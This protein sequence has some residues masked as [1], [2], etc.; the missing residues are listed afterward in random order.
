MP[1]SSFLHQNTLEINRNSISILNSSL[2]STKENNLV[3]A[4]NTYRASMGNQTLT[5]SPILTNIAHWMANDLADN[6]YFSHTDSLNRSGYQRSLDFGYPQG[7]GEN[8]AASIIWDTPESAMTAWKNSPG[9]NQNMLLP[10]YTKIGVAYKYKPDSLYGHYW[11]AEFGVVED[12]IMTTDASFTTF[13][14][15]T[16]HIWEGK[17][18]DLTQA[19]DLDTILPNISAIFWWNNSD[20]KFDFWF[21]GFPDS[22]SVLKTLEK[23]NYYFFQGPSGSKVIMK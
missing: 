23:G 7:A 9:H 17:N 6:N 22:F 12:P 4:I 20:Q 5:E 15:A 21:K 11:V 2:M 13:A 10:F 16:A 19:M 1:D 3:T 8:L 14:G 18:L